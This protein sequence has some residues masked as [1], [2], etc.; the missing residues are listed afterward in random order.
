MTRRSAGVLFLAAL[1]AWPAAQA[2]GQEKGLKKIR[3]GVTSISASNWIPWLAKEA[4]I[5][6]KNGLEVELILLKGSGQT[7]AAILGGSIF[8]APVT[9]TQVMLANLSGA[10]LVT[11]AHTV[12][13]VQSKLVV[14]PEIQRPEQLK[15]KKI[16]TSSLGSLGDFLNRYIMRKHGLDPNRDVTWLMVGTPPERLQA[17]V[18]GNIDAADLSY[19]TDAQAERMGYRILWDARKEVVYPSMSVVTRRKHVQEDRDTVMRM[20]RS[21]VEGI[22]YLKK[23]K[24]FS[25]KVL[26]KYLRNNDRNLLEGSYEIY[27]QD[28]IAVPYP[29]MHGLQ[30]TYDYVAERRPEIRNRRPEEFMDPSFISELDKSGFIARLYE[31]K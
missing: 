21:H 5:Y 18:S 29:I 14:K 9:L 7:S 26:S 22:A 28:F 23:N 15:G 17:L 4:G 16:A 25:I 13:G 10:D 20:V 31:R 8:A 2:A 24:E 30:A 1:L 12:P 19:P 27:R 11:V 3:W 6:E